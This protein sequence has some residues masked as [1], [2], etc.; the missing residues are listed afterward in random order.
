MVKWIPNG[1]GGYFRYFSSIKV[2]DDQGNYKYMPLNRIIYNWA[3]FDYENGTNNMVTR[4]N[5]LKSY[6]LADKKFCQ[7]QQ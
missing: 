5:Q 7:R 4:L 2:K 1:N 3:K 6:L